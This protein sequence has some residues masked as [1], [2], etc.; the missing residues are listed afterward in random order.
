MRGDRCGGRWG[1]VD[2]HWGRDRRVIMG[3]HGAAVGNGLVLSGLRTCRDGP[4]TDT[5]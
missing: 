4:L 1:Y 5:G 2:G 3:A